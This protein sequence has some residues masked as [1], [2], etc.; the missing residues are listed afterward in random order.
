MIEFQISN[1]GKVAF[2]YNWNLN[3]KDL[4]TDFCTINVSEIEGHLDNDSKITCHLSLT[5]LERVKF[6]DHLLTLEVLL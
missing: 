6:K 1:V 2:F 5:A 3:L 4:N